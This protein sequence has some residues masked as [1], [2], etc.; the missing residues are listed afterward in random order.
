MIH[1]C[2]I[3][4]FVPA[5]SG[6]VLA[7]AV[8]AQA[9]KVGAKSVAGDK[10]AAGQKLPGPARGAPKFPIA[11]V[12][13]ARAAAHTKAMRGGLEELRKM[14]SSYQKTLSALAKQVETL[15]LEISLMKI[16][17]SEKVDKQIE[18]SALLQREKAAKQLYAGMVNTRRDKMQVAVYLEIELALAELATRNGILLVLRKR[19]HQTEAEIMK[20]GR[21]AQA[22]IKQ[23]LINAQSR[24]VLYNSPTI[25]LT[26]DLIKYLK[27]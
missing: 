11:V 19:T 21:T 5:L 18:L 9:G 23:Q 1:S 15:D 27:G 2:A 25:D 20:Q 4:L 22:A 24:D 17:S 12:D 14:G 10:P 26:E 8:P 3:R 7:F 6:L 16:A 13:V